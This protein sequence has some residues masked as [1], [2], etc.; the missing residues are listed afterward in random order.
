MK[1]NFGTRPYII[2]IFVVFTIASAYLVTGIKFSFDF[3]QFFPQNDPD[4]EFFDQFQAQFESDDNF[5][6][7][8]V[9]NN[10]DIFDSTFLA[11]FDE[12]TQRVDTL[13]NV[14]GSQ[15]LTNLKF[16]VIKPPFFAM[17]VPA[18]HTNEPSRYDE[19][20]EKILADEVLVNNLISKDGKAAVIIIKNAGKQAQDT[21]DIFIRQLNS[22][23]QEYE[24]DDYYLLGRDNFVA[25]LVKMQKRELG[26]AM[27]VAMLLTALIIAIL[28]QRIIGISIALV[29]IGLCLLF[30]GSMMTLLGREFSALSA[31]YP[32]MMSIVA[33]SDVIHFM[34]KYVDELRRGNSKAV[35][36]ELTIKDIGVATLLTSVTTAAGF[37]SLM[38][39]KTPA[40]YDFGINAAMG[41]VIAY[42]TVLLLT[43][44][45]LSYF[46]ADQII[47]Q[48]RGQAFWD[49]F[50]N[51]YNNHTKNNPRPIA[52]GA[53][54]FAVICG[55]GCLMVTTN[56][57]LEENLPRGEKITRD[58]HYFED[59]FVGFRPLEIA[60]T[61]QG[62]YDADDY[63]VMQEMLKIEEEMK[64]YPDVQNIRSI[65]ALYKSLNRAHNANRLD[66]YKFPESK[67]KFIKY[68]RQADRVPPQTLDILVTRDKKMARITSTVKDIGADE[69]KRISLAID[70]YIANNIDT[71]IIKTQQTGTSLMLDKNA[72][73]I[74]TSLLQGLVMAIIIVSILMAIL[75]RNWRMVLIS[76]VPN[77]L[78]LLVGGA[79]LGYFSIELE[80]S[81]SIIFAIIFGIA[82][83]DT[84]HF[85]S[86]FRLSRLKGMSI[87]EAMKITFLE[88]GKA[89][90]LTTVILF[91]GFMVLLFSIHPPSVKVGVL[92]AVT[93]VS[94]LFSDLYL[95]PVLIRRFLK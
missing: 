8:A 29:S 76:L 34:T 16:P 83:D 41:V 90:C 74:R 21:S 23:I 30:F 2:G 56:Y 75:F 22:M 79:L 36:I 28:F 45:L 18:I 84:I 37:L 52:I 31:M 10:P 92:I 7:I 60:V 49:N 43:T 20:R 86:K 40:I 15:S 26:I 64:R 73:Y 65:T 13:L 14:N 4:L 67:G 25:E 9:E 27:I 55:I 46:D 85:L 66:A 39:S 24:F 19:D 3:K 62:D 69:V 12:L 42:I 44:T 51:W 11:K 33:T 47:K 57:K 81:V 95:I 53:I 63:E 77:L 78:P 70:D 32:I 61:I 38:T 91:F 6:L 80:G 94:A 50:M 72:E 89:I 35:A 87:D 54:L 1:I 5:V 17:T 48:G 93:L 58:Y 59:N 68:Q 71:N 82:V 88:T